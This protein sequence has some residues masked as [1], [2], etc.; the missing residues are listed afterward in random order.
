MNP[1]PNFE[2]SVALYL[3]NLC[4]KLSLITYVVRP[5]VSGTDTTPDVRYAYF[6]KILHNQ[7]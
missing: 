4:L 1:C 6:L 2:M 5:Q 7:S 3:M